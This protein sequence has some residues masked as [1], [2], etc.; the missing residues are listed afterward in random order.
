MDLSKIITI[1]GKP[2]LYELVNKAKNSFV[3]YS[4]IEKKRMAISARHQVNLL[5]NISIYTDEGDVPISEVFTKIF[6]KENGQEAISHKEDTEDLRAYIETI[7]PNYDRSRVYASDLKKIFQWYNLLQKS[8]LLKEESKENH[9]EE[10][11]EVILENGS[12]KS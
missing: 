7:L 10:E 4:L 1:S 12:N 8:D 9:V 11:T 2:G 3:V 6:T 5:E